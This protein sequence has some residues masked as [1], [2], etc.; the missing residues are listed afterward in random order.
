MGYAQFW[1][2]QQVIREFIVYIRKNE[3]Q[4]KAYFGTK[5]KISCFYRFWLEPDSGKEFSNC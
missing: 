2:Q 1:W 4:Q 5:Q 3:K